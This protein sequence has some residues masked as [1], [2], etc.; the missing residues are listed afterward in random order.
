M[1]F[2]TSV[3]MYQ[4]PGIPGDFASANPYASKLAGEAAIIAAPAGVTV[5]TFAWLD[6]TGTIASN[7]G[8]GL[9]GGFVHREFQAFIT[10]YLGE[11]SNLIGAG[12]PVTLMDGGDFWA[13][14]T[15]D[16]TVGQKVYALYGTGTIATAA[17]GTPPAGATV[18]GSISGTTLTV[19]AVSSGTLRVGQPISGSGITAGTYI[20]GLGTGNGGTGTYTVSA[21]QTATSTTVT[22]VGGVET[23]WYAGSACLAGEVFKITTRAQG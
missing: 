8:S 9:V 23:K 7:T 19:T 13:K 4:A 3:N 14:A 1:A 21:S 2:Q 11:N 22:A 18:T 10:Q 6:S 15:N 16:V 5:G 17:T 12:Q 20:T